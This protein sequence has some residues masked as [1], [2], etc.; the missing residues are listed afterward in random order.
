MSLSYKQSFTLEWVTDLSNA[1]DKQ[2]GN[3]AV[4]A[5]ETA[6]LKG[7]VEKLLAKAN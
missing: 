2:A 4:Q 7:Q 3:I 5:G 6:E 1:V